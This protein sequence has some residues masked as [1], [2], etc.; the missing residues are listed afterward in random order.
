MSPE[1]ASRLS[2]VASHQGFDMDRMN[3]AVVKNDSR[4]DEIANSNQMM[5]LE[6]VQKLKEIESRP[7][8]RG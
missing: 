2:R 8:R 7:L 3:G 5:E 1:L 4:S 6:F